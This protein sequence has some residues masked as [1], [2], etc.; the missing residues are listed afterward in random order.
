VKLPRVI[1]V[2]GKGG[3]GKSTVARALA[4]AVAPKRRVLMVELGQASGNVSNVPFEQIVLTRRDELEAFVERIVPLGMIARRMIKSRTFGFVTAA[5]PGLEAFLMLDR[6]RL[7]SEADARV[8]VVDA[9]ATGD[10]VEMLSVPSALE[11]LAV[12]GTLN[13]M[14]RDLTGYLQDHNRFSV[15]IVTSPE[16]LSSREA[17]AATESFRQLGIRCLRV[18]L[19][20]VTDE[21][22]SSKEIELLSGLVDHQR[23]AIKRRAAG[24]TAKRTRAVLRERKLATIELPTIYC[25]SIGD[26][27]RARLASKFASSNLFK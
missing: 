12:A 14:A 15:I 11:R 16:E 5:L 10:A 26:E 24:A 13:R 27:E 6:V 25:S 18:V 23:L 21:L 2:T 22:F 7:M 17:I 3:A 4:E 8:I 1:F 9:P 20:R 19:N